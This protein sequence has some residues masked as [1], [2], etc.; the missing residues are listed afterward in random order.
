[1]QNLRT[2]HKTNHRMHTTMSY[3]FSVSYGFCSALVFSEDDMSKSVYFQQRFFFFFSS[4]QDGTFEKT[5][6]TTTL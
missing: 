3:K 4:M 5:T 6:I 2:G 1:M